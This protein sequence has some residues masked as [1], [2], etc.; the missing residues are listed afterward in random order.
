MTM[1]KY[2]AKVVTKSGARTVMEVSAS[3]SIDARKIVLGKDDVKTIM[4]IT[5]K[6]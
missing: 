2:E 4:A 6:R 3:T 1:H 5:E